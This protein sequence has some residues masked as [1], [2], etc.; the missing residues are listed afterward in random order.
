M[1]KEH[2]LEYGATTTESI[3]NGKLFISTKLK[4]KLRRE[5]AKS[6]VSISTDHS[7]SD[8]DCHSEELSNALVPTMLSKRDGETTS[9]NNNGSSIM[10]PRPS[11]TT[12][13]RVTHS[14]SNPTEVHPTSDALLPTQ[15]GGRS[16]EEMVPSLRMKRVKLLRSKET[17]TKKTETLEFL[18]KTMD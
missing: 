1:R 5:K 9:G 7:T 4:K 16:S 15:D 11:R 2:Q 6:S 10:S 8:Q 14:T 3:N 18:T 12:T 17:Q 13:G